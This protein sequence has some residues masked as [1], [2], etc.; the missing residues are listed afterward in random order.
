MYDAIRATFEHGA[1]ILA[2]RPPELLV[3]DPK[4]LHPFA[5]ALAPFG[6]IRVTATAVEA[7]AESLVYVVGKRLAEQRPELAA[8]AFFPTIPE[9]NALLGAA[10]RLSR[11][12]GAKDTAGAALDVMLADVLTKDEREAIR[13]VVLQATMENVLLDV[14]RWSQCADLSSMRAGLLLAGDVEPARK[15]ILA[16][17]Q[18]PSDLTPREKMAE[19]FKFATSDL[20]ADLRQAIGVAIEG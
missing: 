19:L 13:S 14:K 6:A 7:Q 20:Y 16:E 12:E 11:S 9:L 8:R 18:T 17:P 2:M 1:E 10:V 15:A 4:S 5:P 3:G